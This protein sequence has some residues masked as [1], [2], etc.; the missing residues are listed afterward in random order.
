MP[1][2]ILVSCHNLFLYLLLY[3]RHINDKEYKL[4]N[5]RCISTNHPAN[6][7]D[8]IHTYYDLT[9]KQLSPVI[10]LP[11]TDQCD[12]INTALLTRLQS[13]IVE[14]MAID[15]LDTAVEKTYYRRLTKPTKR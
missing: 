6:A 4:L 2:S 15:T 1:V 10:L 14:L 3:E 11:R 12:K 5:T 8:I 13:E 7:E 9:A